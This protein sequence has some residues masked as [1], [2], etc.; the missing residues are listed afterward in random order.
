MIR[1]DAPIKLTGFAALSV[2][3]QKYFLVFFIIEL[4]KKLLFT[5]PIYEYHIGGNHLVMQVFYL[6]G[7]SLSK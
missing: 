1:L 5:I 4:D 6:W 7:N 3:T 2:E